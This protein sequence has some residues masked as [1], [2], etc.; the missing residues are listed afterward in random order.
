MYTIAQHALPALH[1]LV[2]QRGI[3]I[4][5]KSFKGGGELFI[6]KRWCYKTQVQRPGTRLVI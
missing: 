5:F 2:A 6:I 4:N 1:E 3:N